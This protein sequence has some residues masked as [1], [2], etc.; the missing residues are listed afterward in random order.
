GRNGRRFGGCALP[1]RSDASSG[2]RASKTRS[3]LDSASKASVQSSP[4]FWATRASKVHVAF[5]P[6][7]RSRRVYVGHQRAAATAY[8]TKRRRGLPSPV[9]RTLILRVG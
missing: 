9:T 5:A 7:S 4:V 3:A 6:P 8:V 1:N 2:S